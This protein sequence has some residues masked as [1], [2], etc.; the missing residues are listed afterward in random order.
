[1]LTATL[2]SGS[3]G[4]AQ[5]GGC[6]NCG[7]AIDAVNNRAVLAIGLAFTGANP[8]HSGLQF[9]D[10]N[11]HTFSPPIPIN[12]ALSEA[13]VLD[14]FRGYILSPNEASNYGLFSLA[15]NGAIAQFW[16]RITPTRELDSAAED[17][18]TGIALASNESGG[19][20]HIADLTQAV[21]APGVPG[22]WTAP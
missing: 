19:G 6:N 13:I 17:C 3:T 22:S 14:P 11:T 4:F 16:S 1:T 8:F 5:T 9:L 15:G 20:I 2:H 12:D 21:L 7:V 18:S 10:L